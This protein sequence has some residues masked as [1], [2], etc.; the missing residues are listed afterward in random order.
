MPT[1]PSR[2]AFLALL[3]ILACALAPLAVTAQEGAAPDEATTEPAP[4]PEVEV[5]A[6]AEIGVEAARMTTRL[7]SIF[8]LP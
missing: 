7:S 1:P 6:V 2:T 4:E 3:L 5:I 8:F